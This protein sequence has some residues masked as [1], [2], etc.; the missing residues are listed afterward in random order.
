[1][2]GSA[3]AAN[4]TIL[5][6]STATFSSMPATG[7]DGKPLQPEQAMARVQSGSLGDLQ[8]IADSK[9]N[10]SLWAFSTCITE[11]ND[12][13]YLADLTARKNLAEPLALPKTSRNFPGQLLNTQE[14]GIYLVKTME[15]KFAVLRILEQ[16]RDAMVIQY[17][18]QPA[19]GTAFDIPANKRVPYARPV[20]AQPVAAASAPAAT[21]PGTTTLATVSPIAP[22]MPEIPPATRTVLP[23]AAPTHLDPGDVNDR[24]QRIIRIVGSPSVTPAAPSAPAALRPAPAAV[25]TVMTPAPLPGTAAA[26]PIDPALDQFVQQRTQM[27]QRRLELVAGPARSAPEIDRKAQAILELGYL[28]AD[29]P[30]VAD[31]LVNEIA[32]VYTRTSVKEFSLDALHPSMGALKRLGKAATGAALRGLYRMDLD[33]ASTDLESPAY[34]VKLLANVIR[35]V[36]GDDVA[37][38]IFRREAAQATDPKRKA[39]FEY[40]ISN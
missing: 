29:D 31:A 5:K 14:G 6:I 15:G 33:S 10:G 24:G 4:G 23:P 27:I 7:E 34:K 8:Y 35:A 25:P 3:T 12:T 26:G 13:I 18:Y 30:A 36:E 19:G 1:M 38:F 39:V 11:I 16:T 9:G 28:H 21:S 37:D 20:E 40:L 22:V 32:F 17:V 2:V